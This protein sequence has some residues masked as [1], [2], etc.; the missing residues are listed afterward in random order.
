MM[1][2]ALVL[3]FATASLLLILSYFKNKQLENQE[4]QKMNTKYLTV[5]EELN[6]LQNQMRNLEL[7]GVITAQQAD[8]SYRDRLLLRE[9]ID[10]FNRGYSIESI[11]TKKQL[12]EKQIESLLT[13]YMTSEVERRK[14]INEK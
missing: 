9:L 3:L 6:K 8:I 13:P 2:W 1:E 7:D 10:L 5:M 4:Q 11:A 14:V 12:N